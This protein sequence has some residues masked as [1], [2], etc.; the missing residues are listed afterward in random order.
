MMAISIITSMS[1]GQIKESVT[2]EKNIN[3]NLKLQIYY[4]HLSNRCHTCTSIEAELRKVLESFFTKELNAEILRF[5]VL[6]CEAKENEALAKKYD[7]Y[8]ATLAFT[9]FKD[10]KEIKKIDLTNWAFSK[11]N[12][13]DVFASELK[14]KIEEIIR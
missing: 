8:G 14:Q 12:K 4:F 2:T 11:V 7:A 6:N 9:I 1:Y 3:A 13:P 5:A 10:G